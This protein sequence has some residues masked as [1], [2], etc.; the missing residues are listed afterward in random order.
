VTPP[1]PSPP[2]QP[3]TPPPP[4]PPPQT[5]EPPP[6]PP[7]AATV[8]APQPEPQRKSRL[9]LIAG[10]LVAVL[11]AGVGGGYLI[12]RG[13]TTAAAEILL[14]PKKDIGP[15][16]FT[17]PLTE[18]STSEP[19]TSATQIPEAT[20][21]P[22]PLPTPRP[23]P[24][25]PVDANYAIYGGSN[26][27][28]VCDKNKL[29]QYLTTNPDKG[30]AWA[31]VEGITPAQI[32]AFIAGLTP[33]TLTKDVRVTNHGFA[34][35][36][37]TPR[38]SVFQA[39]TA[40]LV[41]ARGVPVARCLCGNPLLPAQPITGTTTPKYTGTQWPAFTPEKVVPITTKAVADA[42]ANPTPVATTPPM[43]TPKATPA[44]TATAPQ[45]T[46]A[47]GNLVKDGGFETGLV[48]PWGTGIYE[49]RSD[50][51]WGA[52]S[53]TATVVHSN[54][55][56]GSSALMIVN[57]SPQAPN[58]YRTMS[59]QVAVTAGAP[60]CL[61]FYAMSQDSKAGALSIAVDHAWLHRARPGPG[62]Y[63]YHIFQFSFTAESALIDVR[64][65]SEN[66]GTVWVDDIAVTPGACF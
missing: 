52:A 28:S 42:M 8:A 15:T 46:Q 39:G 21:T 61:S 29:V 31:S 55:H 14:E 13:T 23:S 17:P 10:I 2:I 33:T 43:P 49:P 3:V 35:G 50:I 11:A 53:A 4:P 7:P 57:Q 18:I 9:P 65:I 45:V 54:V 40:V 27:N 36:K 59:Q 12:F 34:N 56:S 38:Q 64:V 22:T 37:A 58:V 1:P 20:S 48:A 5:P 47:P 60:Y 25:G 32:P 6:P 16:P 63:A 41:D 19:T 44:P 26:N 30:S 66:T 51:F 24:L 62:T